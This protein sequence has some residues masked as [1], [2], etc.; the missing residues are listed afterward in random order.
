[1]KVKLRIMT[2]LVIALA[3]PGTAAAASG[4]M[5]FSGKGK[6]FDLP[7]PTELRRAADGSLELDDFPKVL[8][9]EMVA[10]AREGMAQGFGFSTAPVIY[11]RFD[12]KVSEDFPS[13]A[14][15][16]RPGA[17]L[18]IIDIDPSSPERGRRFP[19]LARFYPN[20]PS[21]MVEARN[22]LALTPAYG[23]ALRED[24]LYAAGVMDSL[25]D[26]QGRPLSASPSLAAI[27]GGEVPSGELGGRAFELYAPAL[28]ALSGMGVEPSRIA[29]L[30]VF[31]TGDP[32]ARMQ[33]FHEAVIEMPTLE[34]V[35]PLRRTRE[36]D[37]FVVL[38]GALKMPQ[39]QE[40][41]P[42]YSKGQG[43]RLHFDA[44]GRPI[45]QRWERVPV[46]ITVPRQP[47]PER[48]FPLMIYIH[49]T[50]GVSTQFVDRGRVPDQEGYEPGSVG[51][52]RSLLFE[53]KHHAPE[54]T[55]PAQVLAHRGIAAVGAAQPQNGERGGRPDMI[56]FY[57]FLSPEA[58][59]D[60]LLQAAAEAA[61]LLR[62]MQKLEIDPALCP[63]TESGGAA[64]KFDPELS[65]GMGQSLGSLIMGPWGA[66][67][68]ELKALIPA[69]N[70][71]Y[72]SL[73]MSAGNPLAM[74]RLYKSD[75][76]LADYLLRMD[77][78]HPVIMLISTVLAPADP[79]A[80]QG[81]Y[82]KDPLPGRAPK[83]VWAGFGLYDHYFYPVSQNAAMIAMGLDLA[84]PSLEPSTMPA[85][86]LAGLKRLDYP[87]SGNK[88][89]P[90][91]PVTAVAVHYLQDG[92]LDGHHVN[93]QREDAK[94]QYGCFLESLVKN[95][96]PAVF[97]PKAQWDAECG[98]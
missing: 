13:A 98:P 53:S 81:R 35:E 43:G 59:R 88:R 79:F 83:H 34:L 64:I 3:G 19:A 95:G 94:Y 47:M 14:A 36:Y 80:Y 65:F 87:V 40:G 17:S 41:T 77:E 58:L 10:R 48:G 56:Y 67:D 49:G 42:P 38:E 12:G 7:F 62:F 18:F 6:F 30:T 27:R 92:V 82:F 63:G 46:C 23:F 89:T 74:K 39:F 24:T 86:E 73:F 44:E 31:R 50:A 57:N 76:G 54:G 52:I 33:R 21:F 5:E 84:G 8:G 96:V 29:A 37:G 1:M 70:G 60:N 2:A 75:R 72:W 16:M 66:L 32:T 20:G 61:M 4:V 15:S 25:G 28:E 85:L 91:G 51:M 78:F 97:A 71:A 22:L 90:T 68:S 11:F 45:I 26:G 9:L 69:G 55:G 93:Y